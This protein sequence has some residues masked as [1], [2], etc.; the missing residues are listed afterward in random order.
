MKVKLKYRRPGSI[1]TV[2]LKVIII[3]E[4]ELI[5]EIIKVIDEIAMKYKL[6]ERGD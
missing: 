2:D 3:G 1:R 6:V 4:K 5:N